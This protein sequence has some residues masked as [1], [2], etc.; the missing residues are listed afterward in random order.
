MEARITS[1]E[2]QLATKPQ[3]TDQLDHLLAQAALNAAL[4]AIGG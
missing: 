4:V 3:Q 1:L 2:P